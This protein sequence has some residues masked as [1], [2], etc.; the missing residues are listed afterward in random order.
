MENPLNNTE[1]YLE[2]K[3]R[4]LAALS[5]SE[6]KKMGEKGKVEKENLQEEKIKEIRDKYWVK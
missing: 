6:L 4:E 2:K 3:S 5:D 1:D